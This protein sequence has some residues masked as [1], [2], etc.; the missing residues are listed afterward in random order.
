MHEEPVE[1]PVL[2]QRYRFSREGDVLRV[3]LW[4]EPGSAAPEHF[5]PA[6]EERWEVVEGQVAFTIDGEV[7]RAGPGDRLTAPAGVRHA[8]ENVG[9]GVAHLRVEVDP[10]MEMHEV[11]EQGAALN[12]TG[13][14]TRRG[15]P[16][17]PRAALQGAEFLERYRDSVVFTS[18]PPLIAQ[19]LMLYP[20]A[21]LERRRRGRS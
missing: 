10:A 12:R 7:R 17:S 20:L 19:K 11:L 15:I 6:L 14:F 16:K 3:E 8:F 9:N 13:R 4:A 2:Q 18:F 21:R 5:H 1:D